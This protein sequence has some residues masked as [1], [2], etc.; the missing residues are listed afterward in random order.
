M[1]LS[2]IS[3]SNPKSK[4]GN[5]KSPCPS[6]YLVENP[7]QEDLRAENYY[8]KYY[9]GRA[10]ASPA[11]VRRADGLYESEAAYEHCAGTEEYAQIRH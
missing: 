10:G 8:A 9:A 5:L 2:Y 4:I 6:R 3:I 1:L 11:H 7:P